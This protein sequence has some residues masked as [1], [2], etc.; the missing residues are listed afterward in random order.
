M[1]ENI[2]NCHNVKDFRRLAKKKLPSPIFHYI[3]G[4][5]DDER[6]TGSD[7]AH[8]AA[9]VQPRVPG[10]H[11]VRES[12]VGGVERDVRGVDADVRGSQMLQSAAIMI[13][14]KNG[15]AVET[16]HGH[17][18]SVA[19]GA[20][21]LTSGCALQSD[22]TALFQCSPGTIHVVQDEFGVR[23]SGDT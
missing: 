13:D 7:A 8:R 18:E 5:A 19:V 22:F 23:R 17:V 20:D 9:H 3:D 1:F 11:T 14:S 6:E 21:A 16:S 10:E 4:A 12:R 15:D 2:N